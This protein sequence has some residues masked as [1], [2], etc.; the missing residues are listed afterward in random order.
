MGVVTRAAQKVSNSATPINPR[1]AQL[2]KAYQ[3]MLEASQ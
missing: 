1:I 2:G 3:A